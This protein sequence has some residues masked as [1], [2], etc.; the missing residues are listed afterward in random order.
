MQ[1]GGKS[2][3]LH[4]SR[5]EGKIVEFQFSSFLNFSDFLE[6]IFFL[7]GYVVVIFGYIQ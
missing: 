3:S 7:V 5:A 1:L 6:I 4:F 2:S